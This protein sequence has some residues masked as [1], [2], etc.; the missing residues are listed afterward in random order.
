MGE[1]APPA[2]TVLP[3]G[4][5]VHLVPHP[6]RCPCLLAPAP[7]S[8]ANFC[9]GRKKSLL[10]SLRMLEEVLFT[11]TPL[12]D[13]SDD[14]QIRT[15][16]HSH[17]HT[18][19]HTHTHTPSFLETFSTVVTPVT[20]WAKHLCQTHFHWGHISLVLAFKGP[21]VILGLYKCNC[22]SLTVK[23]ELSAATG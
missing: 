13:V 21:N 1:R 2:L 20:E 7:N 11:K 9:S 10:R 5:Y 15:C 8:V 18:H 4:V 16:A 12:A 23:R 3:P 6:C 22:Y 19:T 14:V 17:S